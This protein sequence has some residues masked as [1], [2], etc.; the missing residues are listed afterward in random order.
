[1]LHYDRRPK[2]CGRRS[3]ARRPQTAD[4]E[5]F[6]PRRPSVRPARQGRMNVEFGSCLRPRLQQQAL[7]CR[8]CLPA[9]LLPSRSLT[10]PPASRR[11][12]SVKRTQRRPTISSNRAAKLSY[13]LTSTGGPST[14][15]WSASERASEANGFGRSFASIARR[16]GIEPQSAAVVVVGQ[17][18]G[19]R[20]AMM[21]DSRPSRRSHGAVN[22]EIRGRRLLE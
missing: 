19:W 2:V 18:V 5:T 4:A 7:C 13:Y 10:W 15:L 20:P 11:P 22:N 21:R 14:G 1:M 3:V 6:V 8:L 17:T 9:A 12:A 16:L